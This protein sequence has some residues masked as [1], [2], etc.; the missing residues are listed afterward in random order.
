MPNISATCW[1]VSSLASRLRG[2]AVQDNPIQTA[3]LCT[4]LK[5][6]R[7]RRRWPGEAWSL[8]T[9]RPEAANAKT[10]T[11]SS[12]HWAGDL[13]GVWRATLSPQGKGTRVD[14]EEKVTVRKPLVRFLSPFLKPLFAWN[15]YW[16]TPRGEAG[17]R[18]H[19]AERRRGS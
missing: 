1:V 15:H 17:L 3:L 9:A 7:P 14:I 6:I 19:L 16:T 4:C 8:S 12:E 18:S 13:G 5:F 11:Q 2:C 10:S